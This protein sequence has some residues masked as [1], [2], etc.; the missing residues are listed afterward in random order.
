M[1]QMGVS[2]YEDPC[3]CR[4][5]LTRSTPCGGMH[6]PAI[7]FGSAPSDPLPTPRTRTRFDKKHQE[8]G[9]L[10]TRHKARIASTH[11]D[12]KQESPHVVPRTL[13]VNHERGP[14]QWISEG[15]PSRSDD[16][17]CTLG[18]QVVKDG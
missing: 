10:G 12:E 13:L 4:V 16:I 9:V 15:R 6:D 14:A 7:E 5:P 8:S 18:S 3:R 17:R 2:F 1:Y 11:A